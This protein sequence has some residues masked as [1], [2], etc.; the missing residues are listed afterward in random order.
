MEG[1]W[2]AGVYGSYGGS[3]EFLSYS[4]C[5]LDTGFEFVVFSYISDRKRNDDV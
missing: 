1:G 2:L 5:D 4:G 3:L